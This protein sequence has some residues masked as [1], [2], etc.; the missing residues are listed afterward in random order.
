MITPAK[1]ALKKIQSRKVKDVLL[2]LDLQNKQ[3]LTNLLIQVKEGNITCSKAA[4]EIL[5]EIQATY[6]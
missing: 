3:S 6:C 1:I 4:A 5:K 2:N